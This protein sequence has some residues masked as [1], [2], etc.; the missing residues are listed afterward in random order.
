[1]AEKKL[2]RQLPRV[3]QSTVSARRHDH[4]P[5]L[6][7][8]GALKFLKEKAHANLEDGHGMGARMALIALASTII[9]LEDIPIAGSPR[10]KF[11]CRHKYYG[12][13]QID[14]SSTRWTR[15]GVTD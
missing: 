3:V 15:G 6:E 5:E 2:K 7:G 13:Y 8:T 1:M 9:G 10:F 12:L 4:L 14:T 11:C